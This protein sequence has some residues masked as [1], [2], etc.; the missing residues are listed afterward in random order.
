ME[1]GRTGRWLRDYE[2]GRRSGNQIYGPKVGALRR[3]RARNERSRQNLCKDFRIEVVRVQHMPRT[4]LDQS[5]IRMGDSVSR[6]EF[7][8]SG[9]KGL[10]FVVANHVVKNLGRGA[11]GRR[12]KFH[13]PGRFQ[14]RQIR[15]VK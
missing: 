9:G 5:E 4:I 6:V 15:R 3:K 8:T 2:I 11:S 14:P 10:G 12:R 1:P 7:E 13:V